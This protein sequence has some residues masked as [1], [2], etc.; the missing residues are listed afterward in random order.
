MIFEKIPEKVKIGCLEYTIVITDEPIIINNE[1]HYSGYI[2]YV[3]Q[4]IK[5]KK[6]INEDLQKQIFL[7]EILHGIINYFELE[8][9]KKHEERIIDCLSKG[10]LSVFNDNDF[11]KINYKGVNI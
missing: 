4:V 7:H 3:E 8:V 11:E 9:K 10:L 2:D 6:S 1:C 5:I